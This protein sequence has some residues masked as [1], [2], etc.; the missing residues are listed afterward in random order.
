M[1]PLNSPDSGP[2]ASLC[3]RI[4]QLTGE[5][6]GTCRRRNVGAVLV[7]NGRIREVGWNG[8]ER[9]ADVATCVLGGCPRGQLSAEQQPHGIGYSNCTYLHAEFNVLENFRH[10]VG[11][12]N[13]EGWAAGAGVVVYT[14]SVPCED[15]TKYAVW[16]GAELIWDA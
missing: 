6:M 8:M 11:I 14:S 13:V 5:A 1:S 15:C 9:P 12:R 7:A 10:A 3:G 16:A 4:A 2:E